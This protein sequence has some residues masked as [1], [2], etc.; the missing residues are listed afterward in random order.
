LMSSAIDLTVA[1]QVPAIN[2][3]RGGAGEEV[4]DLHN[5]DGEKEDDGE[6]EEDEKGRTTLGEKTRKRKR[7]DCH[8]L[9]EENVLRG[10]EEDLQWKELAKE[11]LQ[12]VV[13]VLLV[14][15]HLA[16]LVLF[17]VLLSEY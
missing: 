15:F 5:Y 16:L 11:D 6:K 8:T 17:V 3:R 12:Q 9:A 14:M 13:L 2:K 7:K 10:V 4:G 1:A